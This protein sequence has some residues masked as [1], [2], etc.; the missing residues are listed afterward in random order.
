MT[1]D[2]PHQ[3]LAKLVAGEEI[4]RRLCRSAVSFASHHIVV[5]EA[6]GRGAMHVADLDDDGDR[7]VLL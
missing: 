6:N 7:D 4:E 1:S 3:R 2:S 5:T